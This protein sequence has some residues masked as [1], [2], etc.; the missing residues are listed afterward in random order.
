MLPPL[1]TRAESI[2]IDYPFIFEGTT[3]A[4]VD[5]LIMRC[6]H[7]V[8]GIQASL[9]KLNDIIDDLTHENQ[10]LLREM[11]TSRSLAKSLAVTSKTL[12]DKVDRL[13][14]KME[15]AKAKEVKA[16]SSPS[17]L[18]KKTKVVIVP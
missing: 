11:K 16:S 6:D 13:E 3:P 15:E 2:I 5:W 4:D 7:T 8:D 18:P 1:L 12:K 17:P 9:D 10:H 14:K